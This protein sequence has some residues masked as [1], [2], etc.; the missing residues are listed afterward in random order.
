MEGRGA[1]TETLT[2]STTP[3]IY[4]LHKLATYLA[5]TV[6]IRDVV[7]ISMERVMDGFQ[8]G[9]PSSAWSTGTGSA[10]RAPRAV[11]GN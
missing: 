1:G 4:H 5:T 11:P 2:P 8:P 3:L 9:P 10:W 6:H 7:D